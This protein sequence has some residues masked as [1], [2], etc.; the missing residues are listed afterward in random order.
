MISVSEH[1]LLKLCSCARFQLHYMNRKML[2]PMDETQSSIDQSQHLNFSQKVVQK[3][4]C[5]PRTG[6]NMFFLK[7]IPQADR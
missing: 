7:L 5:Q 6:N 1:G 3:W 4:Y 2:S